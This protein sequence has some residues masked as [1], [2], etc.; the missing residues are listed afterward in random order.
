VPG[1]QIATLV[2]CAEGTVVNQGPC[3]V[4]FACLTCGYGGQRPESG[5]L[6]HRCALHLDGEHST[7]AQVRA[8]WRWV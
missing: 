7:P 2:G 8:T 4:S 3:K 6:S 1:Q 5:L